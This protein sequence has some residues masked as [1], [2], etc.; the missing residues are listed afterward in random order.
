MRSL[1]RWSPQRQPTNRY[2]RRVPPPMAGG[3]LMAVAGIGRRTV[4]RYRRGL[5]PAGGVLKIAS[6]AHCPHGPFQQASQAIEYFD[7]E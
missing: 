3:L 4:F 1:Q 2:A 7:E 5:G 6:K